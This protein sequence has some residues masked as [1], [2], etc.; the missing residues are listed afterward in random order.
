[1][2]VELEMK[3]MMILP[4]GSASV[5]GS[6]GRGWVLPSGDLVKPYVILEKNEAHDLPYREMLGLGCDVDD[7]ITSAE[8]V[9]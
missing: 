2:I 3:V 9:E 6:K 1:M 5:D 4:D 8:I 7:T